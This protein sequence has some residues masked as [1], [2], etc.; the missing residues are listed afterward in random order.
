MKIL[1]HPTG[2]LL[3]ERDP[4]DVDLDEVLRTAKR[5]G[6]AV[7]LNAS[8]RRTD[9]NDVQARRAADLGVLVAIDADAHRLADLPRIALGV[10]TARRAW[11]GPAEVVNTW[12]SRSS[13][14]GRPRRIGP[15]GAQGAH[16]EANAVKGVHSAAGWTTLVLVGLAS[17]LASACVDIW[18]RESRSQGGAQA[19]GKPRMPGPKPIF[20]APS[21]TPSA[22]D[23]PIR[24]WP[25][26]LNAL[27]VFYAGRKAAPTQAEPLYRRSLQIRERALGPD[28]PDVVASLNNFA[29]LYALERQYA[30]A[31]SLYRRAL[32]INERIAGADAASTGIVLKN[33][34]SLYIS[35]RAVGGA[36]LVS[37]AASPSARRRSGRGASG[38][39]DRAEQSRGAVSPAG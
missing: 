15:G 8:P 16:R 17:W 23:P 35:Q 22:S 27:A 6:K 9:L 14:L 38:S 24:G 30:D 13:G 21:P 37:S 26:S 7:E 28:H 36:A 3:G 2:R 20:A 18:P 10:A 39:R 34:A 11:L 12:P 32:A 33:L 1:A 25:T 31:E 5:H 4:Y 19:R 29:G